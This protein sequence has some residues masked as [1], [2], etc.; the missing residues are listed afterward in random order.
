MAEPINK[1]DSIRDLEKRI[2]ETFQSVN[3]KKIVLFGSFARGDADSY[4]DID[5]I[6][7]YPTQKR[8]MDRLE[9]LYALWDINCSADI[10]AYTSE[11]YETLL[12]E[13]D[14][15][16]EAVERGRIIYENT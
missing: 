15:I 1:N 4:S 6:V 16:K 12:K 13:R 10:L 2:I 5:L 3:P 9:E 7:V 8:F 11:E 14:F